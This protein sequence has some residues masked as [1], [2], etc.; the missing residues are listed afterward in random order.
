MLTYSHCLKWNTGSAFTVV[1]LELYKALQAL[2]HL[3]DC[4]NKQ[5]WMLSHSECLPP[6]WATQEDEDG[7]VIQAENA[8]SCSASKPGPAARSQHGTHGASIHRNSPSK[9]RGTNANRTLFHYLWKSYKEN[10]EDFPSWAWPASFGKEWKCILFFPLLETQN[11]PDKEIWSIFLSLFLTACPS[12]ASSFLTANLCKGGSLNALIW[13]GQPQPAAANPKAH[14][15]F[16]LLILPSFASSDLNN[17]NKKRSLLPRPQQHQLPSP[18]KSSLTFSSKNRVGQEENHA[19]QSLNLQTL[20][21]TWYRILKFLFSST[22]PF[23]INRQERCLLVWII[24]TS[25]GKRRAN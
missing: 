12:L 6:A 11:L 10:S 22:S 1:G 9:A 21:N 24:I 7:E 15:S 5:K 20:I 25:N 4:R 23:P 3:L 17:N 8:A 2:H 18:H 14:R 19:E 16:V 13:G